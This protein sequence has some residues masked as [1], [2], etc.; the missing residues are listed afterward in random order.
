VGEPD[1]WY[2]SPEEVLKD[3]FTGDSDPGDDN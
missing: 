3:V 1:L 2:Q